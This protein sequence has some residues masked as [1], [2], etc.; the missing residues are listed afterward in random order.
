MEMKNGVYDNKTFKI[1]QAIFDKDTPDRWDN[2]ARV[3]GSKTPEEVKR[4]YDPLLEDLKLIESG[5]VH[6]GSGNGH[7]T[8]VHDEEKRYLTGLYK[9]DIFQKKVIAPL[10]FLRCLTP[11]DPCNIVPT[12][13]GCPCRKG[14]EQSQRSCSAWQFKTSPS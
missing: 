3:V 1:A 7:G 6:D 13:Q 11:I 14:L 2:I 10:N 12:V 5:Q 9:L 4:H 8:I